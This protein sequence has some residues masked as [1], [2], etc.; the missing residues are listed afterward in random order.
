MRGGTGCRLLA[1]PELRQRQVGNDAAGAGRI[2]VD[3]HLVHVAQ[4]LLH[5]VEVEPLGRDVLGLG[6]LLVDLIEALGVAARAGDDLGLVGL[7]ALDDRFGLALGPRQHL[8]AIGVGLV[9]A[10]LLVGTRRLDVAE[11]RDHLLRRVDAQQLDVGDAH[12]QP[13][14]VED[15]LQQLLGVLL[16]AAAAL[17]LGILQVR[18]ADDL[19]H[20]GLGAGAHVLFRITHVEGVLE[21]VLDLPQHGELD[22]DDVLVAGQH[23][24]LGRGR[25]G[26]RV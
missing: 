12:A 19:A 3:H 17:G 10:L 1:G 23:Q 4:H 24:V 11:G 22:V 13:I 20:G 6:P 18:P 9:D 25:T 26:P 8:V 5:G 21:D 15:A 7:A 16:D 2:L 14:F